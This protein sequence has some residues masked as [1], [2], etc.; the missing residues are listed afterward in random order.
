MLN[1][2]K[3]VFINCKDIVNAYASVVL[4]TSPQKPIRNT[5][6]NVIV[7]TSDKNPTTPK[8]VLGKKL[9]GNSG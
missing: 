2:K 4:K 9:S 8:L 1:N 7:K 6:T 3:L 5:P